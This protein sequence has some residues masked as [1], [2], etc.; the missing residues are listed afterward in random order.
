MQRMTRADA[1]ERGRRRR[2]ATCVEIRIRIRRRVLPRARSIDRASRDP[3]TCAVRRRP[4]RRRNGRDDVDDA[5]WMGGTTGR[6]GGGGGDAIVV[7]K[8]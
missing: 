4:H 2:D 5:R 1:L 3:S 6:V 7:V 8:V